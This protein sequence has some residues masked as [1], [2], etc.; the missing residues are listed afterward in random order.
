[1]S[2]T[3]CAV[4]GGE[5]IFTTG[6]CTACADDGGP[7]ALLFLNPV[8][9][10]NQGSVSQRLRGWGG[11]RARSSALAEVIKGRQPLARVPQTIARPA[12]GSLA[13]QGISARALGAERWYRALPASFVLMVICVVAAG[14]LA[15]TQGVPALQMLSAAVALTLL[16]GARLQLRRPL[17]GVPRSVAVLPSDTRGVL[18]A[19]LAKL[20]PG[21]VQTLVLDLARVG[22]A[23]YA[24]LP[25][26]LRSSALGESVIAL[27]NEVGPLGLE[28]ARLQVI[29]QTRR[30]RPGKSPDADL[31]AACEERLQLL[32]QTVDVLTRIARQGAE[33]GDAAAVEIDAERE[34]DLLL[35]N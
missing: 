19:S 35:E 31:R 11:G 9:A 29:E 14:A 8:D 33:S 22:E 10:G 21:R 17:L 23:T 1:M 34:I 16:W 6:V 27:V 5:D 15:G 12:L 26:S 30:G 18:A 4:C 32:E 7:R 13:A 2:T 20:P 25:L 24:S 3:P 28:T